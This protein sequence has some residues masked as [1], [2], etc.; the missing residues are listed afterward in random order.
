MFQH[1]VSPLAE[2][3]L[4]PHED[5]TR[6]AGGVARLYVESW[7]NCSERI[8]QFGQ[9]PTRTGEVAAENPVVVF[10]G[11]H[12]SLPTSLGDVGN[13]AEVGTSFLYY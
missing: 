4:E 3:L 12:N 9:D 1:L 6:K 13:I 7:K 10:G 2:G 5:Q 8:E 11:A